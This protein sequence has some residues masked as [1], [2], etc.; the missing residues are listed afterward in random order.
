[1]EVKLPPN[2]MCMQFVENNPHIAKL[3]HHLLFNACLVPDLMSNGSIITFM[4]LTLFLYHKRYPSLPVREIYRVLNR[5]RQLLLDTQEREE[6]LRLIN[7]GYRICHMTYGQEVIREERKK[8]VNY[9]TGYFV[10][11]RSGTSRR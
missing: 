6:M 10:R 8:V 11:V 3:C 4:R 9:Y 5:H 7:S 2:V 1:M